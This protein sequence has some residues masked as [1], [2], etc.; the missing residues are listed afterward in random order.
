MGTARSRTGKTPPGGWG[1]AAVPMQPAACSSSYAAKE[2]G[3][4][5]LVSSEV[6]YCIRTGFISATTLPQHTA[7]SGT[8][9]SM[10]WPCSGHAE[11]RKAPESPPI[12]TADLPYRRRSPVPFDSPTHGLHPRY[13]I[14]GST[15]ATGSPS[16][17]SRPRSQPPPPRDPRTSRRH[18]RRPPAAAP[19]P[20]C[21]H[22]ATA[23]SSS[24]RD[25][26]FPRPRPAIGQFEP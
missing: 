22:T 20:T 10:Q 6:T 18:H 9:H 4:C 11:A 21:E 2:A 13:P 25:L 26:N 5:T 19:L 24:R 16:L 8:P 23:A 15:A 3:L 14:H 12:G 17:P 1:V 7:C